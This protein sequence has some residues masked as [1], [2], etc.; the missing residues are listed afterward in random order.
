M[1]LDVVILAAG[2]GS[3]MRS[4]LPKVLHQIGGKPMVAHVIDAADT[5][6]DSRIHVVVGHG[7]EQV[8]QALA[9]R[10]VSFA[11]QTEQ[12]GTG[13]A[14]AQT[15]EQIG[16]GAVLILYG[17][18]PLIAPHTL[19][20][21]V[22][23]VSPATLSLL[24]VMLDN[25]YGYGRIVRDAE[26]RVTGIVEE[27]DATDEQRSI[28]E[29]NTGILATT[30]AQLKRWLPALSS[31]NAQGEYYLTDII[32][33][34]ASEGVTIDTYQPAA[35]FEVQGVNDRVQLAALERCHQAVKVDAIMRAGATVADPA[36]VDI[37]G[38]LTVGQDVLID[39]NCVF[40][41]QVTLGDGVA[42]GPGCIIRNATIGA[43]TQVDAYSV[44]DDAQVDGA[45]AIG[46][47]ARLRPG[48]EL[49]EGAKVGNFVEIK[50]AVLGKGA[51]VNHLS[52]IGDADVGERVNVGA[53]SITCNYD[54]VNKSRTVLGD[55]VFIGSNTALVAPVKVGDRSTTAAGSVITSDVA[56]DTLAIGRARQVVKAG[57]KRPT[58]RQ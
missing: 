8:E 32:A 35:A 2:Q 49:R 25:P 33:M 55:D 29:C 41:G 6:P 15:L 48:A 37:R 16:D 57:W 13:H 40:E 19:A 11:R 9:G 38:E 31:D 39:I 4:K 51:K 5:L 52:Y 50:K 46:P 47:F 1:S 21:M 54:G 42:I 7:S 43:N 22:E 44:I 24:T 20:A 45:N 30:G 34:A 14:V 28:T 26:Q 58:K 53:G 56:D 27:K 3:R 23:N 10:G 18:V 12:K 17:D 36:R